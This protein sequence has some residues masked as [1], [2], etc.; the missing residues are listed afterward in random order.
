MAAQFDAE[1]VLRILLIEMEPVPPSGMFDPDFPYRV[2]RADSTAETGNHSINPGTEEHF[3]VLWFWMA[4]EP[5]L[6]LMV[7][8]VD[9]KKLAPNS[10]PTQYGYETRAAFPMHP[11][12]HWHMFYKVTCANAPEERFVLFAERVGDEVQVRRVVT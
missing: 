11:N 3:D 2:R 9:T 6:G 7:D 5:S 10:R 1:R 4:S 8:G 12:E